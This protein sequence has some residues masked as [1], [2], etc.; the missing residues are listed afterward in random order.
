[1]MNETG[2]ALLDAPNCQAESATRKALVVSGS[3][4]HFAVIVI[5]LAEFAAI[6]LYCP[7]PV[8]PE[9]RTVAPL[10]SF[11]SMF[12]VLLPTVVPE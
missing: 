5:V 8:P 11:A 12:R 3:I 6:V 1:M 10:Y 4:S 7:A 2:D 9:I